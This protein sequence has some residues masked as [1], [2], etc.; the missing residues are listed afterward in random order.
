[1]RVRCESCPRLLRHGEDYVVYAILDFVVDNYLPVVEAMENE[2]VELEDRVLKDRVTRSDVERI[3]QLRPGL[4]LQQE[5]RRFTTDVDFGVEAYR[6]DDLGESDVYQ[7]GSGRFVAALD[8][9]NFFLE[10][11]ALRGQTVRQPDMSV[12]WS[13]VPISTN[14]I[15]RDS[16]YAGPNFDYPF[17]TNLSAGGSFQRERVHYDQPATATIVQELTTETIAHKPLVL[18]GSLAGIT[19]EGGTA[20]G[21]PEVYRIWLVLADLRSGRIVAKGAARATTDG[22]DLTPAAFDRDSP[23]WMPDP[24]V[25][26][27]LK[28]C[29]AKVGEPIDPIYLEGIET[30]ALVRA[31]SDAYEA[32]RYEEALDLYTQASKT[33]AGDQLRVGNLRWRCLRRHRSRA[34]RT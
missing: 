21:T 15:D 9:D 27:Y 10:I 28:T 14:R 7:N 29:G 2:V 20:A 12:P 33:A 8:P 11:G 26:G 23:G 25:G 19:E 18:L 16:Y 1:M 3:Y 13:N 22:V 5:S 6:Y 30:A 32:G 17:G 34:M 4:S 24:Y 31:A